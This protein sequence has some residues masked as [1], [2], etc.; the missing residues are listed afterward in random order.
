MTFLVINGLHDNKYKIIK[1]LF[2]NNKDKLHF[3]PLHFAAN[4]TLVPMHKI[5]TVNPLHFLSNPTL[6]LTYEILSINS[7]HYEIVTINSLHF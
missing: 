1:L 5:V 2:Q 6:V 7:L 3:A 4:L